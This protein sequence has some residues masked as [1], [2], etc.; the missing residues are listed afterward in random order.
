MAAVVSTYFRM[1]IFPHK[2]SITVIDQISFFAS[3]SQETGSIPF[4]H[5]TPSSLQNIGVGIFKDSSLVGTFSLPLLATL[6]EI[7]K[8]ETCNMIPSTSSN[9]WN[10]PNDFKIDRLGETMPLSP[11]ELA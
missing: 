8:I 11:I 4:F 1:V 9:L 7:A 10:I 2:G 3:H 5:R 6:V